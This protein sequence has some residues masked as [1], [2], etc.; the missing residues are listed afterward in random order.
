MVLGIGI[1]FQGFSGS[2]N[3]NQIDSRII[4]GVKLQGAVLELNCTVLA[5][6]GIEFEITF[7]KIAH[8]RCGLTIAERCDMH[9]KYLLL[10]LFFIC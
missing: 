6:I 5:G 3:W 9:Q 8:H 10:F 4:A 7:A 1:R 2:R